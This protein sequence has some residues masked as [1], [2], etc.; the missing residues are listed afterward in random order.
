MSDMTCHRVHH[1]VHP[2]VVFQCFDR[3]CSIKVLREVDSSIP[4]VL[5][6]SPA[7]VQPH[8]DKQ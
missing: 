6:G 1:K 8:A 2:F 4:I 5:V 3:T 7:L